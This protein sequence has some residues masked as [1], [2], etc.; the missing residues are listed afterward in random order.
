MN[1]NLFGNRIFA[2]DQVIEVIRSL[3]QYDWLSLKKG[4]VKVDTEM[5]I[6]RGRTVKRHRQ[7]MVVSKPRNS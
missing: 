7:K 5:D 6:N 4:G 3:I 2:D 1:V